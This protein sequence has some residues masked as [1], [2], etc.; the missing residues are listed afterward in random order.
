MIQLT[1]LAAALAGPAL[2][3]T[4]PPGGQTQQSQIEPSFGADISLGF[5]PGVITAPWIERGANGAAIVRYE[6]FTRA[7]SEP[8]PRLGASIWA[9]QSMVKYAIATETLADGGTQEFEVQMPHFGVLAVLRP[10]PSDPVGATMGFGF[11]RAEVT[12][13]YDGPLALPVL[14]FELG[15][16]HTLR[17]HSFVDWMGRVHWASSRNELESKLDEWW[18]VQFAVL[19]GYHVN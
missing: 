3:P 10:A 15:A 16:R 1:L 18:M 4:F 2:T 12:D 11:G 6:A 13:Y 17:G 14:S 9:S 19:F 8:G 7:R 5:A